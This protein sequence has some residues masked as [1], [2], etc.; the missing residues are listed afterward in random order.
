MFR[1]YASNSHSYTHLILALGIVREPTVW[2]FIS[3]KYPGIHDI[4]L[5]TTKMKRVQGRPHRVQPS[6]SPGGNQLLHHG[7]GRGLRGCRGRRRVPGRCTNRAIYG[8]HCTPLLVSAL[9]KLWYR[10]TPAGPNPQTRNPKTSSTMF[11]LG[12]NPMIHNT[13]QPSRDSSTGGRCH[14]TGAGGASQ[15]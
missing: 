12:Q 6:T 15:C 7:Q 11:S 8:L 9:Q 10:K 14:S 4:G 5:P 1:M 3:S 2:G 13:F